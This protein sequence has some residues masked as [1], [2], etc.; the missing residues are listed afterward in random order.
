MSLPITEAA[1]AFPQVWS[2]KANWL[3]APSYYIPKSTSGTTEILML[4]CWPSAT[5]CPLLFEK[6]NRF[7]SFNQDVYCT[8]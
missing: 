5:F 1:N 3:G 6:R 2:H 7:I 4:S 8:C